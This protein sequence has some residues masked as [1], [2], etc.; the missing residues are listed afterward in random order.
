MGRQMGWVEGREREE[1][2]IERRDRE[3]G[4]EERETRKIQRE[5]VERGKG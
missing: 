1:K 5:W 2:G 3:R 4:G